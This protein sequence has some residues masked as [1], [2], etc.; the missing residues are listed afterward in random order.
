MYAVRV[1]VFLRWH[2]RERIPRRRLPGSSGNRSEKHQKKAVVLVASLCLVHGNS[3]SAYRYGS[4][5]LSRGMPAF[6]SASLPSQLASR[7]AIHLSP[8]FTMSILN[9]RSPNHWEPEAL[10][11]RHRRWTRPRCRS[12][13]W[14][15]GSSRRGR[16][17]RRRTRTHR[18]IE[19]LRRGNDGGTVTGITACFPDVIGSISVG[20]EVA[21]RSGER[22][23]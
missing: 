11:P 5:V 23:A 16:R 20:C 4:A 1:V 6:A 15:R 17:R 22:S 13:P 18:A 14:R 10:R 9:R 12:R 21:P 19:E 3:A 2:L 7:P 8:E